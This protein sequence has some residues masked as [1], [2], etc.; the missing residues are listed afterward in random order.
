MSMNQK[1]FSRF[2]L[3]HL[4]MKKKGDSLTLAAAVVPP[5]LDSW[6]PAVFF[7]MLCSG[8]RHGWWSTS[9]TLHTDLQ[10]LFCGAVLTPDSRL[11]Q[12]K[13]PRP[14]NSLA[15]IVTKSRTNSAAGS[16]DTSVWRLTVFNTGPSGIKV[17]I[18]HWHLKKKKFIFNEVM[19]H[20][21]DKS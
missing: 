1:Q 4:I 9:R 3:T 6:A 5:W 19:T 7:N 11:K 15:G 20:Y 13:N 21:N 14:F 2:G 16:D 8:A 17:K 12:F 18:F 10:M